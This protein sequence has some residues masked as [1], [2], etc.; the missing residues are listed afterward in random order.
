M[1]RVLTGNNGKK[2]VRRKNS[3]SEENG[4]GWG[5]ERCP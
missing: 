4:R 3:L 2:R 1:M 5:G